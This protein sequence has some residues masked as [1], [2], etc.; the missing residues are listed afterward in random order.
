MP[1]DE[2][3]FPT[4][5]TQRW[6]SLKHKFYHKNK[7]S[8]YATADQQITFGL[9]LDNECFPLSCLRDALGIV[10]IRYWAAELDKLHSDQPSKG[11]WIILL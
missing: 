8:I 3:Q 6:S 11:L 9:D 7:P 2:Y 1:L 4:E 10:E 5:H